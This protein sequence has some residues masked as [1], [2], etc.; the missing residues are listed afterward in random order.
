LEEGVILSINKKQA[1]ISVSDKRGLVGLAGEL[2]ALGYE[3]LSTGG[4]AKTLKDA[5]LK[6]KKVS[7]VTGFPEIL[8]G[9]VKTLHPLIHG[10]I[11]AQAEIK[12]QQKDLERHGIVPIEIVV[13]NLYPFEQTISREGFLHQEAVENIDI[14]G[15]TMIRAA[16]KNHHYVTVVVNP[17]RYPD[18]IRELKEEGRVS[19][20]TRIT[21]AAEAFAH[22]AC[23]DATI[24]TYFSGLPQTSD[25][26]FPDQLSIG[27]NKVQDLRYGENPQQQAAFYTP[28]VLRNGLAAAVQLKGKELSFNNINDLG[29]A[30]ALAAEFEKPTVVAVKHA[31][32]CGV[33]S[34]A[35]VSAAYHLAY[36]ADP[37]SI[38][39]GVLAANTIIDGDAAR[40]MLEIFLEVIAAPQF[41]DEALALLS[42]KSDLRI[43]QI[44]Q[45]LN[46]QTFYDIKVAAGAVLVQTID[47]E[48][49][50]IRMGK[51]VSSRIPS[52]QEWLGMAFAQKVVK[53]VRSN[54]I[55]IAN[56]G[57]T[58]G[59]GAGQMNRIGAA[60]IA[61][62]QG[63]KKVNG[64]VM[65]SD[66]FFPF[67]DV[68]EEAAKAGVTA[69]VQPGGSLK[70]QESIDVCN[71]FGLAMV[72]TGRRYFK[73]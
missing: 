6:V 54:A 38:F 32:P 41:T 50:N 58:V 18:L 39:G 49:V 59:I 30:W 28:P 70:D 67:P 23:Y 61:I 44:P 17:D 64:S 56:E 48:P 53:H 66:A 10:A 43:L 24:A 25:V 7:E 47:R 68:A 1:L 12:E 16:A 31:N 36:E 14:G 21:L 20:E 19:A 5:G 60:K 63:G 40:K 26:L 11:L 33:G 73:H 4:T 57:Q 52:E 45:A 2:S 8:Q 69:I 62:E 55:V 37:V 65:G 3:L 22:T 71:R 13:V 46:D 27:L 29:T 34:A 51:V 72:F 15:P 35:T 42:Q 9:R